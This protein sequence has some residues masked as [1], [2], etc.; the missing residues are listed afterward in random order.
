M[1][2]TVFIHTYAKP[3]DKPSLRLQE[4]SNCTDKTS[5]YDLVILERYYFSSLTV[6]GIITLY[7]RCAK[8]L[9]LARLEMCKS[10]LGLDLMCVRTSR[11]YSND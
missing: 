3:P 8:S 6:T 11:H 10:L 7:W 5:V 1:C 2:N 4:S 9:H